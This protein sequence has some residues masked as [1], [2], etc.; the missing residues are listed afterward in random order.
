MKTH[1]RVVVIGGGVV[2]CSVLFHLTKF[3]WRDVVLLERAELTAGSSWHA[4]GA[5]HTLNAD[6]NMAA[7]QGYT[8]NLYRELEALSDLSCGLHQVGGMTLA[9]TPE[10]MDYL[11]ATRAKHRHM[12]LDTHLIGPEEIRKRADFVNIDGVLGALWDPLDGHLDPAGTTHVYAAAARRQGA[13]IYQQTAVTA[14]TPLAQGEWRVTTTRGDII[15]EHVVNAAGLWAREVA[16]LAGVYLPLHPMEHQYLVTD[17]LAEIYEL[18]EEPPQ[19]LDPAGATYLRPEGRGL[20][21]GFYEQACEPWAVDGTPADFGA[22]LLP[23]RLDRIAPAMEQAFRRFPILENAGIKRVINGP[24]TFSPDGNPLVGPVPGLRNYWAACAVMAGFSQGGG[25]GLTLAEWM[26]EGA[27]SRD[28]FALDVARFGP[29]ITPGYTRR[30]V[31]EYYQR[32]FAVSYP[33]EELPAARPCRT[34][35]MHGHWQAANAVFGHVY[36]METVNYFA[37]A[38]SPPREIPSFRRSDGFA[39]V[40]AEC[41]AVREGVGIGDIHT[42]SKFM[43]HGPAAADWLDFMLAGRLPPVGRLALAPMLNEQGGVIGDFSVARLTET[44]FQLTASYAAQ[45]FHRRWFDQHLPDD[46]GVAIDNLSDDLSGLHIA[47][48]R[49]R[50]LLARVVRGDVGS[51]ALPFMSLAE[52]DLGVTTARI[53][54]VSYTGDL[55][56]EI[57]VPTAEVV[58]LYHELMAHGGDLGLRPF[59]TRAL[60]SLRL[61]K[62]FG[63]WMHEYKPDYGPAETGLDRFVAY[64]KAAEFIGKSAALATREA[65]PERQLCAFVVAAEDADVWGDEPI[66]IEDTVVGF[67]TSGGF[68]HYSQKS[69]AL[70]F[71]PSDWAQAGL[72]VEIEILGARRPATLVTEPL[73][74]PAGVRMRA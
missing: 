59:G 67:V 18:P 66:W 5:F 70:G 61:E 51:A 6:T 25:V 54:R 56:Y 47:G 2:G 36:G 19:V 1:A 20:L 63:A 38:G 16:A 49:A 62:F 65:G 71:V 37:P 11:R 21:I 73:F 41:R 43:V 28:V 30:K 48:P 14:L 52:M 35:P 29:W 50:D 32:R 46:G 53:L 39:A 72:E 60:M 69:V 3:G 26:V 13:E 7:L 34:T 9:T 15:A 4:A 17:D 68:A 8:I 27:A 58:A 45:A 31:I 64:G 74:D 23:D 40:G 44:R 33:N 24:F 55:G 57:Y 22:E 12:G 10:R 42:F